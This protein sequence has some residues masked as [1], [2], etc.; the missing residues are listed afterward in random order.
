VYTSDTDDNVAKCEWV[1]LH[2]ILY[3]S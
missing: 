2:I 3:I 1:G